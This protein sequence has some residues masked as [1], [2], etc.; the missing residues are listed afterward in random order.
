VIAL[1]VRHDEER[2]ARHTEAPQLGR[3]LR[4]RWPFVDQNRAA[5]DLDQR[6]VALA[7]VQER[8][9][10]AGRRWRHRRSVETPAS[11]DE[12]CSQGDRRIRPPPRANKP[13]DEIGGAEDDRG[14]RDRS[15][16]GNGR[17]RQPT[18]HPRAQREV[19]GQPPVDPCEHGGQRRRD[20]SHDRRDERDPEERG[21]DWGC[22]RVRRDRVERND[23]ELREQ[24]RRRCEATR[25][26]DR[27]DLGERVRHR[28]P[29]QG[30]LEARDD[31]EDRPDGPERE[32]EAGV[33][34]RVGAPGQ[35]EGRAE[36]QE[37]PAITRPRGKP[38]Q[39]GESTRDSGPDDGRLPADCEHVP[40]DRRERRDLSDEA[41]Q[42]DQID[43][44]DRA[45]GDQGDVLTRNGK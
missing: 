6:S 37:V 36:E 35:Q 26:G 32:L 19:C 7:D 45:A 18:D 27:D 11:S 33:Q 17:M 15:T 40:T 8:D 44:Q 4:F 34:E 31:D 24:D 3:R 25:A 12:S 13:S 41:R 28:V 21:D 39:R 5:W 1:R 43:E 14:D 10:Q 9:A 22:K 2:Q 23:S 42:S 38:R 29:R 16:S 30:L 20:R